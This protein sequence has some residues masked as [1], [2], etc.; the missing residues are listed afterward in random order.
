MANSPVLWGPN[1]TAIN[2]EQGTLLPNGA[3]LNQPGVKSYVGNGTFENGLTSGWSLL[4]TTLT[5]LIPTGTI[6]TSA[7]SLNALSV[8]ATNPLS[9][10]YSLQTASS[11][12]W[13]VGQGFI[14]DPL[15]I[16][17]ED[18]AK[19]LNFKAS[20]EV[21]AGS[22]N[23]NASGTS[24]NT[25]H[26][27]LYD[28]ANAAT[29]PWVQPSGVY[30]FNS[31]TGQISGTFQAASNATSYRLAIICVNASGGAVSINW[32][33][34][35]LSPGTPS[36]TVGL[37]PPTVQTFSAGSG[38]YATPS[39]ISYIQVRLVGG[40]GG[41]AGGGATPI[42]G[43]AGASSSF[44]PLS[45]TGGAAAN[46]SEGGVAGLGALTAGAVGSV[47]YGSGGGAG[48]IVAAGLQ[49]GGGAGGG[50]LF[51]SGGYATSAG[52]AAGAGT[53]GGGGGG[54][55]S[56]AGAG[57]HYS[58]GGGGAGGWA[59]AEIAYPA[60]TYAYVIGTGGGGGA[61]GTSN[62][63]AGGAG[64][65]EVTEFYTG[66]NLL[67]GSDGGDGRVIAASVNNGAGTAQA[68]AAN[69]QTKVLFGTVT[70][71]TTGAFSS[72][73]YNVPSAGTYNF[74]G[75]LACSGP[76]S[77]ASV[78]AILFKNGSA[79]KSSIIAMPTTGGGV[80]YFFQDIAI[81]G[82]YYEL[83]INS[84]VAINVNTGAST[85]GGSIFD[86]RKLQ[87]PAS[88]AA[89]ESVNVRASNSS[90]Q[91]VPNA[92]ATV[93]TGWTTAFDSHNALAASTGI[94]TCPS[95]GAYEI[96]ALTSF[97]NASWS[98][99]N[100]YELYLYKNGSNYS[101]LGLWQPSATATVA[102]SAGGA[103]MLKLLAGDTISFAIFQNSGAAKTLNSA[104]L[105]HFH[106]KRAGN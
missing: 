97:S 88:I 95:A 106:I 27:Y 43:T 74:S 51:A 14:S 62:G 100:D 58:G 72:S 52:G 16:D 31:F 18:R 47:G 23:I 12:A 71:D 28:V 75:A 94:W 38:T 35:S 92:T 30:S 104:G 66:S 22:A 77:T 101:N 40:G 17:R 76:A 41:G 105:V 49:A 61:G 84:T 85:Y 64:Y 45:A 55:G 8:T 73:R 6:T 80:P 32:D 89:G 60:G 3:L 86:I 96:Y 103:D 102:A 29:A 81:S 19:I 91:S 82:D 7:A 90:G 87:G 2:L 26:V 78:T 70:Q 65:I 44:G 10:V 33:D 9:G 42:S 25:Y 83:W 68:I 79:I 57:A 63:G 4:T 15:T 46:N 50:S 36:S 20:F 1:N 34:F 37:K 56:L 13:A 48:G 59:E 69:T 54:G 39:G 11:A 5:G 67:I 21:N 53:K 93:L 99:G 98:S 24:A